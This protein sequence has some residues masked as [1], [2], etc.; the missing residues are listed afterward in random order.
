MDP[1]CPHIG[2]VIPTLDEEGAI[3]ACLAAVGEWP[4]VS[5]VVSDGGSTDATLDQ[6]RRRFPWVDVVEGP[7]GRGDQLDRGVRAVPADAYV[8]V[9]ADCRL[10]MG[11]LDAVRTALVEPEVAVGCFRLRTDPPASGSTS[12]LA[13]AW[14]RLLD[15]RSRGFFLPYGDQALFL[16]RRVLEAAGGV[17]RIALME[18]VELVRRVLRHGRLVRV[19]LEVRTTARRFAA[20]PLRARICTATFPTLYRLGVSPARLARWYGSGR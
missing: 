13:R 18:D 10:P 17:P 7:P 14:W 12:W 20:S 11:W 15:L 8:F 6:V 16:T 1:V 2:V 5:V 9:H 19:P 3:A 4:D